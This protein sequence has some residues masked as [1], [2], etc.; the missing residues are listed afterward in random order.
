MDSL[1]LKI[2]CIKGLKKPKGYKE[3]ILSSAILMSL[4]TTSSVFLELTIRVIALDS[5]YLPSGVFYHFI[6]MY[7]A[8]ITLKDKFV[9]QPRLSFVVHLFMQKYMKE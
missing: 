5:K 7:D 4:K 1:F 2:L 8:S 3:A 6:A 9:I